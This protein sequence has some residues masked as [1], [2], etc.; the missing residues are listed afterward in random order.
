MTDQE[1]KKY[2]VPL[3]KTYSEA[4]KRKVV[5]EVENGL[6]SKDGAKYRYGI[7]GNS[8]VLEWC[9]KY[10]RLQHPKTQTRTM[11]TND[12]TQRDTRKRIAELEKALDRANL[13]VAVYE[14]MMEVA[15]EKLGIDIKKKFGTKP[16][17]K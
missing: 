9:R 3:M 12:D 16:L 8:R 5:M 10:G 15:K 1:Q 11:K 14:T 17:D 2:S 6:L 4:F 13:K 7:V